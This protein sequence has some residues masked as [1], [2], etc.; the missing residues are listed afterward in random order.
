MSL[1]R[2][3][4]WPYAEADM[5]HH[6]FVYSLYVHDNKNGL[7]D[8]QKQS[9]MLNSPL[10]I[11][12]IPYDNVPSGIEIS[13]SMIEIDQSNVVLDAFKMSE[14][15]QDQ[16]IIRV[17]EALG[18]TTDVQIKLNF[19]SK[20]EKKIKSLNVADSLENDKDDSD[21]NLIG[22]SNDS[23]AGDTFHLLLQPFKIL[24]L[25]LSFE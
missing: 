15:D 10:K 4:K 1:L 19:L 17:H 25:K 20:S 24:T 13:Q 14:Y 16:Y 18:Y 5:G 7:K 23:A 12:P 6:E 2:S 21:N 8:T 22:L 3:P 9:F 11:Y